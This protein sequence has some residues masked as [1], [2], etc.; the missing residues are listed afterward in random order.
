MIR[1]V[2]LFALTIVM[3][4]GVLLGF[5][6]QADA[7]ISGITRI[8]KDDVSFYRY[9]HTKSFYTNDGHVRLLVRTYGPP[10]G[11]FEGG[12]SK[13]KVPHSYIGSPKRISVNTGGS[14]YYYEFNT[15]KAGTY[16]FNFLN[17]MYYNQIPQYVQYTIVD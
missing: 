10:K 13:S 1:K 12:I 9:M 15:G 5:S 4:A 11:T 7:K 8:N 16:N 2:T 6:H 17:D 3:S 14:T